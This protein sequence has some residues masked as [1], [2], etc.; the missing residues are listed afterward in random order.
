MFASVRSA[1]LKSVVAGVLIT[2]I[3]FYTGIRSYNDTLQI[4]NSEVRKKRGK[5][6]QKKCKKK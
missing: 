6:S 2:S 4:S 5:K 1:V 3:S